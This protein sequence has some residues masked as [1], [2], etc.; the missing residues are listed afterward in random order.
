VRDCWI[1]DVTSATSPLYDDGRGSHLQ[2]GGLIVLHSK[3]VT[4]DSVTMENAQNRGDG[5]NGYLFEISRSSEIL[6]RDATAR[7]GRHNF[8]QNWDFG[9]SGCVFQRTIS[10]DGAA[11]YAEDYEWVTWTGFSEFHHSLAMANLIDDSEATDGWSAANRNDYS[12]GAGHSA[13]QD[14][15]WNVRGPGEITSLQYGLGYV[16]GTGEDTAIDVEVWDIYDSAGTAPEDYTE[17]IGEAETL[18]PQ[19]LYD[20]QLQ[21][22]LARGESLWH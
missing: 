8:I 4:V 12:S 15:F 1:R 22:R 7:A 21:R 3:R 5:G 20:D 18:S 19:S 13:T 14:V 6:I 16:I 10:E 11:V 17:G 2:S 9:T